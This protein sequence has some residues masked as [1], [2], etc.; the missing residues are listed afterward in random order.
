MNG[1]RIE[2]LYES[3][4][5]AATGRRKAGRFMNRPYSIYWFSP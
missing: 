1:T 5:S 2:A 3:N 4:I